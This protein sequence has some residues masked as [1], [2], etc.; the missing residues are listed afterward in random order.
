MGVC[1]RHRRAGVLGDF[2]GRAQFLR[3]HGCGGTV[4]R[5][6]FP[7]RQDRLDVGIRI[8]RDPVCPDGVHG[9]F[10]TVEE[11]FLGTTE[12]TEYTEVAAVI[13]TTKYTK[14]TKSLLRISR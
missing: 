6:W 11:E 8:A 1:N 5:V 9:I 2:V 14:Y 4:V 12:Y 3:L 10:R 7:A 13:L